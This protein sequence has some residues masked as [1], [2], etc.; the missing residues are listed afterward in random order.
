MPASHSHCGPPVAQ[1]P[2]T[3]AA[4]PGQFLDSRQTLHQV[5]F[6]LN[7]FPLDPVVFPRFWNFTST[8]LNLFTGWTY[9][10]FTFRSGLKLKVPYGAA[11]FYAYL[12]LQRHHQAFELDIR[13]RTLPLSAQTAPVVRKR[14]SDH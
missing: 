13:Q 3:T 6:L 14:A 10:D 2:S 8:P 4:N 5:F 7:R 11:V 1:Q 9:L 12:S